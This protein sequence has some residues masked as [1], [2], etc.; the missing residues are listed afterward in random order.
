MFDD[1][2]INTSEV[3]R[4]VTQAVTGRTEQIAFL[5]FAN[6]PVARPMPVADPEVLRQGITVVELER[7]GNS[8]ISTILATAAEHLDELRLA[9][10]TSLLQRSVGLLILATTPVLTELMGL[11][12]A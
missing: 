4:S 11:T 12:D 6:E 7:S 3:Q 5:G 2:L 9:P 1:S 10:T 8:A